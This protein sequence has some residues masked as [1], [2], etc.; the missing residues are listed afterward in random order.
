MFSWEKA[1]ALSSLDIFSL[2]FIS[3]RINFLAP[4]LNQDTGA[5]G[6]RDLD[7][8]TKLFLSPTNKDYSKEEA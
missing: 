8:I 5:G 7:N 3:F 6:V 2:D 1:M 4:V